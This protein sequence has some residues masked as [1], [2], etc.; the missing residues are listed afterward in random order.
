[1]AIIYTSKPFN[2]ANLNY[3]QGN[4]DLKLANVL[5]PNGDYGV[6]DIIKKFT[7]TYT[8]I[9]DNTIKE[10][11]YI[12]LR[13][14]YLLESYWN[15]LFKAYG[16]TTSGLSDL[17]SALLNPLT[18]QG[19]LDLLYEG[20][21]DHTNPTGFEYKFPFFSTEYLKTNNTW[22]SKPMFEELTNLQKT[23][24]G[25]GAAIAAGI[26]G[27]I[28]GI[29]TGGSGGAIAGSALAAKQTKAYAE[30]LF[31]IER[32]MQ[33]AN[34]GLKSPVGMGIT[35]PAIDK[36]HLWST[37]VPRSFNISFPL[38]N[39]ITQPDSKS[40]YDNILKNW[41]LCHL[42]CYQNLYNKR[43]LFTGVP[44]VFYEIDVPGVHY[45]KAGYASNLQ[46]FNVGNIRKFSLPI[47]G[48][49]KDV[50][51]PDAY[52]VNITITDFFIPSKN[53]MSTICDKDAQ[54]RISEKDYEFINDFNDPRN[55]RRRRNENTFDGALDR[56]D[57]EPSEDRP[58]RQNNGR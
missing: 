28:A 9:N 10:V 21:Y 33:G 43:N 50:N 36:P 39:T 8:P 22:T 57:I 34:I 20:L 12:R 25:A 3:G 5:Q 13:E 26:A 42:L 40:W 55:R 58:N 11:P 48:G 27:G 29:F 56:F 52:L 54:D 51:V 7:W 49:E 15:Q 17:T 23:F 30:R 6:M 35:D 19:N 46:I 24:T 14:F 44:P 1:M 53:F 2:Q 47:N 37:T 4:T 32:Y 41:E 31:T 45:S 18:I 16:K 38:Y